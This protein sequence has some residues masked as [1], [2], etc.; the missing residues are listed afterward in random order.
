MKLYAFTMPD[1]PKNAG[2]LKIGETRGS[3]EKRVGQEGHE[4]NIEHRI[5][6]QDSVITDR[7]CIDKRLHRLLIEQGFPVQ[8]FRK[9][10][11]ETELIQ[12][13][14]DDVKKAFEKVK[15]QIYHEEKQ[16]EEVGNKFYIELRNW[17]YWAGNTPL[18]RENNVN[19]AEYALRLIFRL[20]LCFFLREKEELIPQTLFNGDWLKN[21]L[22]ED[23]CKFYKVIL[24]NLFHCLNTPMKE[25][26]DFENVKLMLNIRNVKEQFQTIPFLNGGLFNELDGDEFPLPD[27]YF[28]AE[29]R[30]VFLAEL[31]G[32]QEETEGLIP[33]LSK[34]QYKL[35]LDDLID[36]EDYQTTI[37]PEF[38][39]KVF[40]SLLACIDTD[41]KE[42][43]RKVTGSFYTPR[44]IVDY[45]VNE[46]LDEYLKT[47][48][49]LRQCKI[50]DPA[51]GS[52]AFPCSIM[53]VM[54][55]RLYADR[56]LSPEE[57]YHKKL[58]ILQNV[59]YGVDIQPMAVQITVLRLFLSLLQDIKPDKKKDNYGIEPLPNLETK[60]VCADTLIGLPPKKFKDL[61]IVAQTI[62]ALTNVRQQHFSA[63]SP[64]EKTRLREFDT[65]YRNILIDVYSNPHNQAFYTDDSIKL[66]MQWDPYHQTKPAGFF[67]PQWMFGTEK[68]DIVIGNPPYVESRSAS[69]SAE[70]KKRYQAQVKTDFG[71]P[72]QYI[73]QGSDLS[74]Y[75]FP[76]S[77]ALLSEQG[78]GMLIIQNGWLNTDYGAKASQFLTK[79]LQYIRVTDSPFRHFDRAS[80]NVNTVIAAFKKQSETKKVCFDM[81]E[82]S[83]SRMMTTNN[84]EFSIKSS[85][86]SDMKWGMIM[87]TDKEIFSVLQMVIEKGK[88]TDQSFYTIGQG[89]N[90]PQNTFIPKEHKPQ[91]IQKE[92]IIN[93]VF[94]EYRYIY[95]KFDYCLYHSFRENP[96]DAAVL[97][98]INASELNGGKTLTRKYPVIIMPRGIGDKHFAGWVSG[99]VLSNSFVDIYFDE[100][101]EEKQLNIWLFCNSGLFFLYR[102]LSGRRNLGGG[103]LKSEAADIKLFPLYFPIAVPKQI[104]P[105][106]DETET[107]IDLPNRLTTAVQQKI[108]KLVFAHFAIPP[109]LQRKITDELLRVFRFRYDKARG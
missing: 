44:E 39:G 80:V 32:C 30:K 27:E 26:R 56:Q 87:S 69:I 48:D 16:R 33:I 62:K 67:D 28:F 72:A 6:W 98:S 85:V 65:H 20:I 70:M 58:E 60:F 40:E 29:K 91:F 92:N 109:A 103:L 59:I 1:I 53:N 79:T 66:L 12:C 108:D 17:F 22:K 4:L 42:T 64:A 11:K 13:T 21:N 107:V 61:P 104:L 99:N 23:G 8:V 45:M 77:I 37:D 9:S 90:V 96:S 31:G 7:S 63:R 46:S 75:F 38:L 5:V 86:L 78:T 18:M 82:K 14:V 54:M 76:R 101:D 93:A 35:S 2:Y 68:F 89:I 88:E 102:E 73:T 36:Q 15:E 52:G 43:R 10:G 95:K 34:Y 51:C 106:L 83:G 71:S 55:N 24:R 3:V 49:D 105:L 100:P 50:L 25:H 47:N 57:K 84:K 81:M 41:S 97:E 19:G 74:I 94:K